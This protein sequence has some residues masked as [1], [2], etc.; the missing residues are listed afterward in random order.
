L[1]S[2]VTTLS[3]VSFSNCFLACPAIE[4]PDLA[5]AKFC[6]KPFAMIAGKRL[7]YREAI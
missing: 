3:P 2:L 5:A 4:P 7:T 1:F 6:E